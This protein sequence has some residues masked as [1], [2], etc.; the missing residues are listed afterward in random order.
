MS[1]TPDQPS[2]PKPSDNIGATELAHQEKS[3]I[4]IINRRFASGKYRILPAEGP[5]T[6]AAV[7]AEIAFMRF[8]N[9][10]PFSD[11]D[12]NN[13]N[14]EQLRL[15]STDLS[16]LFEAKWHDLLGSAY[17]EQSKTAEF[18]ESDF[19]FIMNSNVSPFLRYILFFAKLEEIQEKIP[20]LNK[21]SQTYLMYEVYPYLSKLL[22][23]SAPASNAAIVLRLIANSKSNTE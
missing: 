19:S 7:L 11:Q 21:L 20:K 15:N 17:L 16:E 18:T 2:R 1:R 3:P 22:R 9:S 4:E 8:F 10:K 6:S 5:V 13:I 12:F 23:Q 14:E